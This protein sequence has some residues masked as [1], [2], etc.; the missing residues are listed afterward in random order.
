M[1]DGGDQS[2]RGWERR[3]CRNIEACESQLTVHDDSHF[4]QVSK[5]MI[6]PERKDQPSFVILKGL[7]HRSKQTSTD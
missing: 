1:E 6:E 4:F 7:K 3:G 5:V 2:R